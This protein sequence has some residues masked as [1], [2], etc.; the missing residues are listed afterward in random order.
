MSADSHRLTHAREATGDALTALLHE[1][2]EN[3]LGAVLENPRLT[4]PQL[5]LLLERKSL[6]GVV[7]ERVAKNRTWMRSYP[8]KRLVAAHPRTPRVLA[9]PLL[10]SLYLF[11]LV[12]ASLLPSTPA[13]LKRLAEETI[14]S[15]LA[16]LPLGQKK[17]L[18]RRGS[19]RV[20]GALLAEGHPQV[21]PL[22]TQNAYLTEAHVLKVLARDELPEGVAA[23]IAQSAKWSVM[24]NVR[25]AL[26]RNPG[27]PLARVLAFLPDLTLSTLRDLVELQ[28][29]SPSLREYLRH[30]IAV[31]TRRK[32]K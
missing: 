8:V 16:Q 6:P 3:V 20:A 30:E 11:D 12:E 15:K 22:A 26:V 13:E 14:L 31:R 5:L 29:L 19:G 25:V 32:R 21:F 28:T 27:T 10:R 23:A 18:A 17:T 7:L 2:D 24:P 9:I 4:E 1:A